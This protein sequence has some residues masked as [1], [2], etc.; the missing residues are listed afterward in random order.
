MLN[1]VLAGKKRGTGLHSQQM[2]LESAEG[3]EDVLTASVFE[4][5]SYLS[6]DLLSL[7]LGDLLGESRVVCDALGEPGHIDHSPLG[8]AGNT[9]S[10]DTD[11]EE[12]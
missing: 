5:L 1:A 6:E 10:R 3:A 2:A 8:T 12:A 7:V 4:R 9:R 11:K